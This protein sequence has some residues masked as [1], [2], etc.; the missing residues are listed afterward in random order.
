MHEMKA[1]WMAGWLDGWLGGWL[2]EMCAF[3]EFP[4]WFLV[5]RSLVP[6][7][8]HSYYEVLD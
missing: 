5:S 4:A 8:A 7:L 3:S 1:G 2:D 6:R